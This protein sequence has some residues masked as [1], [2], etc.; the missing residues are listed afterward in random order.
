MSHLTALRCT[1]CGRDFEPHGRICTCPDCGDDQGLLEGVFDLAAI[2]REVSPTVLSAWPDRTLRRWLPL[3]PVD[4]L[5]RL[6]VGGTP[7][8]DV[9]ALAA[10]AGVGEVRVKDDGRNP[11]ASFKDRASAVVLARALELGLRLITTASTGNAA[12]SLAGLAAAE[13]VA[14]VIF[15]PAAA[16]PAKI[17]QLLVHGAEV[18]AVEGTYDDAFD[19]SMEATRRFGWFNR[20]TGYNP[21]T[22][23]GKKTAAFEIAEQYGWSVPDLVFV[24]TGDGCILAGIHK[25][26]RDL[27]DLG[28]IDRLPR[29]VAVQARGSNA[30]AQ[31]FGGGPCEIAEAS[32][33]ADSISVSRP[34]VLGPALRALRESKGETVLV[35]DDEILA[36][37]PLLARKAGV[38][39]EPAAAASL[40]GLL[41]MAAEGRLR[42]DERVTLMVTGNGLKDIAAAMRASDRTPLRM[43]AGDHAALAEFGE[44]LGAAFV[45]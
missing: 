7:L 21:F 10:M 38:F 26:F 16:P 25:G 33:V 27:L 2:R 24:P 22:T 32:T 40:A 45:P 1:R 20:S 4:R 41:R 3:L 28:W 11:T 42:G 37:I 6:D 30:V 29:L 8:Y 13:G 17:A 19:L 39:A 14:T 44:R 36:A 5:P 35:G 23:E 31:A 9:P 15:V 43:A 18:V 12:S 34:R